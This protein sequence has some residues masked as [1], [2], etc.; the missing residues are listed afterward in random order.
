MTPRRQRTL[1]VIGILVGAGIG[2]AVALTAFS[3]N[4]LYYYTPTQA[5]SKNLG[6]KD[7]FR[8]GGLVEK[9]TVERKAGSLTI[10]FIVT[11]N[12]NSIPVVFTGILPNLFRAGQGVIVN[13]HMS[14]RGVFVA[15]QVLAKHDSDYM[16]LKLYN[17]ENG[18]RYTEPG[19][20]NR[21]AGYGGP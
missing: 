10:R 18:T 13:G 11:D 5:L 20:M 8:L 14:N 1:V 2:T 7:V 9:G 6:P 21:G 17:K 4:L 12:R 3:G 16:P 15:N 19:Q